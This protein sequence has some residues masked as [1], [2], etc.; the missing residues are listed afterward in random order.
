M[1][2]PIRIPFD[3]PGCPAWAG[4]FGVDRY[5]V[6]A[7]LVW[8]DQVQRM[9]WI[10]PGRFTMGSP[11]DE[12][13]GLSRERPRHKVTIDRGI[14][15]GKTPVTQGFYE[16]ITGNNPS[17]FT[18]EKQYPV[19]KVSWHDSNALCEKLTEHL[20]A[21]S[22][23]VRLPSE[24]EWEY[25]CR[26][27]TTGP[28]YS[29]KPLTSE[30]GRCSNLDELAWYGENS[31]NATHPVGQKLPNLWGLYDML[32]N[33]WEWCEDHWH[34]DYHG[35]PGNQD[36]WVDEDAEEGLPR[37]FRGGGWLLIARCCRA[38]FRFRYVPGNRYVF[39][40]FRRVLVPS[41]T[42]ALTPS[43]EQQQG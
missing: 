34:D 5:G 21:Q 27:G 4:G 6:F 28:L 17:Y 22:G 16:A 39:L 1:A 26:A 12:L 35:A 37:V 20:P 8:G 18:G 40:G 33:V 14:W 31:D 24:A 32:G 43:L 38:A 7:D 23:R 29:G 15:L 19:E 36:A 41:S 42:A 10:P 3:S 2:N 13:G 25:A 11:E 30:Y 9:R